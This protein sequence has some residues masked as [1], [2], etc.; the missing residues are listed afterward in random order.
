M[1]QQEPPRPVPGDALLHP[2]VLIAAVV[3]ALN[4]F[5][6]KPQHPGW[7]SGK[8]SDF[9]LCVFLPVWLHACMEWGSW[10]AAKVRR[11]PWGPLGT[12][13][14]FLSL[15]TAG[16]YFTALQVL[17]AFAAFHVRW[18]SALFPDMPFAVTPDLTDLI[19]LPLLLLPWLILN[20]R[21]QSS[22]STSV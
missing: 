19:A 5:Y 3:I 11:H 15:F 14:I 22:S 18:L 7:W 4:T 20:R 9:G 21:A 13:W 1:T 8:L 16:A 10:I 12:P 2:L 6:L 17:P